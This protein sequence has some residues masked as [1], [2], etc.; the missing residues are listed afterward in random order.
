MKHSLILV[1]FTCTALVIGSALHWN[2]STKIVAI[3][4]SCALF[5]DVIYRAIKMIK[6]QRGEE[7]GRN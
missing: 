7:N 6:T 2:A 4:C 3:L 5:A 1:I